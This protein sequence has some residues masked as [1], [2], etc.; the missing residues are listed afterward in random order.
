MGILMSC[1]KEKKPI[2][3]PMGVGGRI[4][5]KQKQLKQLCFDR[6]DPWTENQKAGE[7][8]RRQSGVPRRRLACPECSRKKNG[9]D[10]VVV[11]VGRQGQDIQAL[12]NYPP[13]G[14]MVKNLPC[15]AEDTGST[16]GPGRFQVPHATEQLTLRATNTEPALRSPQAATTELVCRNY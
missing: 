16:P 1:P 5:L 8:E 4:R 12:K 11:E 15:N 9:K 3:N 2:S 6:K 13:G 14:P 10:E 7:Q